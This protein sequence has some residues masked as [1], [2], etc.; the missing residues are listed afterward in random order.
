MLP[1]PEPSAS[2]SLSH[3]LSSATHQPLPSSSASAECDASVTITNA[4]FDWAA[5][6]NPFTASKKASTSNNNHENKSEAQQPLQDVVVVSSNDHSSSKPKASA[7]HSLLSSAPSAHSDSAVEVEEEKQRATGDDTATLELTPLEAAT[8]PASLHASAA[9]AA[10]TAT[11]TATAIA[12]TQLASR[13]LNPTLRDVT[14]RIRSGQ[15]VLIVGAVGSG[16]SSL[17][18]ALLGEMQLVAGPA[19]GE[20]GVGVVQC[21]HA[22][23]LEHCLFSPSSSTSAA[24]SIPPIPLPSSASSPAPA[25]W[26][27]VSYTAQIPWMLNETIRNNIVFGHSF[28][29]A[30]YAQAV[31]VCALQRDLDALPF[32]DQTEIGRL[33]LVGFDFGETL[34]IDGCAVLQVRTASI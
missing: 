13:S 11:A 22:A 23:L 30:R 33:H 34:S 28:D 9:S 24:S 10:T 31:R 15:L 1:P 26:P 32:A 7:H 8:A 20:E 6:H 5:P 17:L 19:S 4:C 27:A 2:A 29:A 18:S 16:K 3:H 21:P 14:L 12:S 25:S